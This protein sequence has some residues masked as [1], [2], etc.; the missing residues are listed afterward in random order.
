VTVPAVRTDNIV[1]LAQGGTDAC[2]DGLFTQVGVEI[3][4][5]QTLSIEF[6]A[7]GFKHANGV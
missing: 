4:D 6:D 7:L 1:I 3:T 2:R 5:D